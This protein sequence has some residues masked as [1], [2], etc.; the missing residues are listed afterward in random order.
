MIQHALTRLSANGILLLVGSGF[1]VYS[2]WFG[3]VV[4]R[5]SYP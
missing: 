5:R 2:H 4:L 3:L 1:C